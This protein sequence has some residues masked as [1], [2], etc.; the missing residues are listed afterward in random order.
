M[1][2]R[3]ELIRAGIGR[4]Y[5][6]KSGNPV[7]RA[8]AAVARF[9]NAHLVKE[10]EKDP[11]IELANAIIRDCFRSDFTLNLK[12]AAVYQD[13]LRKYRLVGPE[14]DLIGDRFIAEAEKHGEIFIQPAKQLLRQLDVE[15][16]VFF[17]SSVTAPFLQ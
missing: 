14:K 6:L 1:G 2:I 9:S 4:K 15:P 11:V 7:V 12:A 3:I 5:F 13:H 16:K 8:H 17:Y 10:E